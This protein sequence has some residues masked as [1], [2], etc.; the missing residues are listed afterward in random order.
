MA[1]TNVDEVRSRIILVQLD[2]ADEPGT[3]ITTLEQVV[4]ENPV[5]GKATLESTLEGVD[6][7][8]AFANE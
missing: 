6:V 7:V 3:R 4:A 2:V 8:N 5:L 1:T